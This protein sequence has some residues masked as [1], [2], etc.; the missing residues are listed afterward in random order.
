M[1]KHT[2]YIIVG[3][4]IS[5]CVLSYTLM[6]YGASVV[7]YDLPNEN[8]SSSVA[9]G[10]WNPVVLKR[11]KKV[12]KA[13]EMMEEL[14]EVYPDIERWTNASFLE[15]IDIRRVFASVAEQNNWLELTDSPALSKYLHGDLENLPEG[16]IGAYSSGKMKGT[17][18][19]QVNTFIAAVQLKLSELESL[20]NVRFDW[21]KVKRNSEGVSYKG[22]H[23]HAIISCEGTQMALGRDSLQQNGF[24]PVKGELIRAKLD[25]GLVGECIHQK[26]FMLSEGK[27]E[28]SI[29]ATYAWEG[30]ESGPTKEKKQ[31]LKQHLDNVWEGSFEIIDQISGVRPATKDRRPMVGPHS[32]QHTWVFSGMGSR[33]VLMAPYLAK[34]LVEHF[35]YGSEL[36]EECLPQRFHD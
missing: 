17:G 6:K 27:N 10:L 32:L 34:V 2:D 33:A 7:M 8:I 11:M 12:W 19:L 24:A 9:A 20:Q 16:I 35:F 5:G 26:H 21:N 36:L 18:R 1:I 13:D 28:V 23:A 15:S 14:H 22:L 29:G 25:K 3:G 31:V 30:F 4:G